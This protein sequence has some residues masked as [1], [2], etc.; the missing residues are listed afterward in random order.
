MLP[1]AELVHTVEG[2]PS[3]ATEHE[4]ITMN[5][6]DSSSWASPGWATN[7]EADAQAE[8]NRDDWLEKIPLVFILVQTH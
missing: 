6:I 2:K 4:D 3:G 7:F 5:Q 1:V 8:G